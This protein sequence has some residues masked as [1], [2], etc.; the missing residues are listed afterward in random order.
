MNARGLLARGQSIG[1]R[2]RVQTKKRNILLQHRKD[3]WRR[4][5]GID[6]RILAAIMNKQCEEADVGTDVEDA[7]VVIERDTILQIDFLVEDFRKN[8]ARFVLIE[9]RNMKTVGKRIK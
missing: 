5:E 1:Q 9:V 2:Y 6:A 7:A 4:F 8:G 3:R